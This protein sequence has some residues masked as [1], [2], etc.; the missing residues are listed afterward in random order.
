MVAGVAHELNTPLGVANL[1]LSRMTDDVSTLETR[2][3][4][5]PR[6][7]E[8]FGF[9]ADSRSNA[10]LAQ[11]AIR[12]CADLVRRFKQVA[13]DRTTLARRPMD[14]TQTLAETL[15]DADPRLRKWDASQGVGLT[16]DL[17]AGVQMD[18]YRGP[19]QQVA[20]NLLGNVLRHAFPEGR[21]GTVVLRAAAEGAA[22]VR[23]V[24][25]DDGVGIPAEVLTHVFEPF[26]TTAR[27]RGGTGL[28]LHIVHQLVSDLVGGRIG[29]ASPPPD[30]GSGTRFT[31]TLP[32][33]APQGGG[34]R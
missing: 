14:L 12:R 13:V 8:L 1:S 16:L 31:I 18:S 7:S 9:I 28:G 21:G 29:V 17:A 22:Q 32:R 4:Q 24:V 34:A 10:T 19:L 5:G 23:I 20:S 30:A 6:R 26:F 27:G 33:V 3:T 2:V 11:D 25:E 15:A